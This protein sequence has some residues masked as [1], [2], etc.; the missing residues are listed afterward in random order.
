MTKTV[1]SAL[2]TS[3]EGLVTFSQSPNCPKEDAPK[4]EFC[5]AG[6]DEKYLR[7]AKC[8]LERD[9]EKEIRNVLQVYKEELG[10]KGNLSKIDEVKI[11]PKKGVVL[12]SF[13]FQSFHS[14]AWLKQVFLRFLQVKFKWQQIRLV[15]RMSVNPNVLTIYFCF[16]RSKT[17]FEIL[18]RKYHM[19]L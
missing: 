1:R 9:T 2:K 3:P 15:N 17:T 11:T 14:C 10:E 12:G 7:T 16:L 4:R 6:D 18:T 8:D 13:H 19:I 5:D